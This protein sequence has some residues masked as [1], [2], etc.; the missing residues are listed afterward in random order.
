MST[1]HLHR[2]IL[3]TRASDES[4][5][6]KQRDSHADVVIL[7][8]EDGIPADCKD[9]A[10]ALTLNALKH[11]N[12]GTKKRWVRVNQIASLVGYRD[13]VA[14]VEG[15]PDAISAGKPRDVEEI[16]AADYIISRRE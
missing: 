7:E 9:H 16:I 1:R 11:W 10:R 13:L 14:V 5:L 4:L 12:Y 8:L 2:S 15:R 3:I 6:A